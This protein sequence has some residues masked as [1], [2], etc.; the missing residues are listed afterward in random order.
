MLGSHLK[1][2]LRSWKFIALCGFGMAFLLLGLNFFKPRLYTAEL[3]FMI[4]D[5]D[6]GSLGS[7]AAVLGQ[8]GIGGPGSAESN[9]DK[10]IELSRT[11]TI[12]QR[13]LCKKAAIDGQ[14]DYLANHLIRSL[15]ARKKWNKKNL[16]SRFAGSDG[17]DLSGFSFKH[18][19]VQA[20]QLIENKALKKLHR[21]LVGKE[22]TGDAFQSEFS[23]VSGIMSFRMTSGNPDLSIHIVEN[24]FDELSDFYLVKTGEKQ[25]HSYNLV[26]TKYDSIVNLLSSVQYSIAKFDDENQG[27]IRRMDQLK[28]KRMQGEELKLASMLAE[29]EKQLQ[30]SE[31]SVQSNS[32][33]IQSIDRP[34]PPLRPSNKGKLYFFLLGGLLGGILSVVLVVAKKIYRDIMNN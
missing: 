7:M 18:D 24:I 1:H 28:K 9:L 15:E 31:L 30:I 22:K 21:H 23:E 20:F 13:A 3:T 2:L 34:I 26:K 8:F 4:N 32:A 14:S 10:I 17:L 5:E 25:R 27:L 11:R 33:F 12:T 19:S 16:L 6:G 29:A